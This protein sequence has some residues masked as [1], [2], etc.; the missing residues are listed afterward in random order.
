MIASAQVINFL[1]LCSHS[2]AASHVS[3]WGLAIR[4]LTVLW[5]RWH[6]LL[7][8][9]FGV[10]KLIMTRSCSASPSQ[11]ALGALVGVKL[12]PWS[13][14]VVII[15]LTGTT[16]GLGYKYA[17]PAVLDNFSQ[18]RSAIKAEMLQGRA[19]LDV[20]KHSMDTHIR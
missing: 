6:E 14:E 13:D 3:L 10:H 1:E 7:G 16:I 17:M 9:L 20:I 8:G 12:I 15:A 2:R 4:D 19:Q 5:G 11:L 18:M